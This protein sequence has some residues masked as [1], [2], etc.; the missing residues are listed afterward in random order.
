MVPIP[1]LT[2]LMVHDEA[3]FQLHQLRG[4]VYGVLVLEAPLSFLSAPRVVDRRSRTVCD[5]YAQ[6]CDAS[7]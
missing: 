5:V 7:A 1:L 6:S 4:Q 2:A 3:S